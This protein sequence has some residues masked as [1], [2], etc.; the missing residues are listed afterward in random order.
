VKQHGI[1]LV[2]LDGSKLA[3]AILPEVETVARAFN[4]TVRIM[5][6][7]YSHG[8]AGQ[9]IKIQEAEDYARGVAEGLKAKGL[10]VYDTSPLDTDAPFT[11]DAAQAILDYSKKADI[12]MMSTHGYSGIKHYLLG[13]VAEKVVHHATTPVYLVRSVIK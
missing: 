1:I 3:E 13:S 6:A 7:C 4:A 2:P 11:P 12:I 10:K 5:R 9:T 8:E